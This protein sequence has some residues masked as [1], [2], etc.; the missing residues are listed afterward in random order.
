MEE[1]SR[2]GELSS[3]GTSEVDCDEVGDK[4]KNS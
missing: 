1:R 4:K 3:A 2:G